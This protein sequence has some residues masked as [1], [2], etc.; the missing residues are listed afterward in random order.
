MENKLNAE[1]QFLPSCYVVNTWDLKT[2]VLKS[3]ETHHQA[4]TRLDKFDLPLGVTVVTATNGK[5]EA[6]GIK[7]S[8]HKLLA[9]RP[10]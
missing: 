6:R 10:R 5:L 3:S 4:W 1:K 8:N 7:L 2:D 9:A